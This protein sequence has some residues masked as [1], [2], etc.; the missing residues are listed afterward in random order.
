M[1]FFLKKILKSFV[2]LSYLNIHV[3]SSEDFGDIFLNA[4]FIIIWHIFKEMQ[5]INIKGLAYN[6]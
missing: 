5:C 1:L 4:P 3:D 6:N 2:S